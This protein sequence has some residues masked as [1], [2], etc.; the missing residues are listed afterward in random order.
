MASRAHAQ[1]PAPPQQAPQPTSPAAPESSVNPP[2]QSQLEN[3][4][5]PRTPEDFSTLTLDK[6]ELKTFPPIPLS[7]ATHDKFTFERV[8]VQWRELDPFE[9]YILKPVGVEKPPVIV[10]LY[11]YPAGI[12]AFNNESWAERATSGGYAAVGFVGALTKDRFQSRPMKQTF[13]SELPESLGTTVHDV[14]M[15]LNYL[16]TRGDLD[17]SNVGLLGNGSGA[18]V[19]ILAAAADSRIKAVDALEPWGDWP[20]WVAKT[21]NL[22]KGE[23]E[24]MLTP[25]FLAKLAPL[26]PVKW[27]P[28]LT[29]QKVFLQ[30][31]DTEDAL[32]Q[33]AK[34]DMEAAAPKNVDVY[35]YPSK[36][37]HMAAVV[38]GRRFEWLKGQLQPL[39]QVSTSSQ[40]Q[41]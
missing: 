21:I 19:A 4:H 22:A 38:G 15:V 40:A 23:R 25:E 12:D 5:L 33:K 8:R 20:N 37:Q 26:D 9:L 34:A 3:Y 36:V 2:D 32:N 27:L 35:H 16:Q 11:G 13:L 7:H 28:K 31:V 1:Q 10:Y 41:K 29:T 39:G 14:Q 17:M 30:F 24:P 18:T 6:S